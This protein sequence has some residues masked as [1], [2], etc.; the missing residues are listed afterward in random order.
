MMGTLAALGQI[1]CTREYANW[2]RTN[3]FVHPK[4]PIG[5]LFAMEEVELSLTGDRSAWLYW[6][7]QWR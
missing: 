7:Y 5:P 1:V 2:L 4:Y 3:C 6:V